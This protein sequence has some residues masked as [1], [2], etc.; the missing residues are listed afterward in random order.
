MKDNSSSTSS[1]D[2]STTAQPTLRSVLT[3]ALVT[4]VSLVVLEAGAGADAD[5]YLTVCDLFF[6]LSDYFTSGLSVHVVS[7]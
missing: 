4:L 2:A 7:P 1:S 3:I 5:E 6:E